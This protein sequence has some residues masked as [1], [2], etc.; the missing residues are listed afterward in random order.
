MQLNQVKGVGDAT[1]IKLNKLGINT[2]SDLIEFFPSSYLDMTKVIDINEAVEGEHAVIRVNIEQVSPV[3]YIRKGMSIVKAKGYSSGEK[4]ELTWFN[5]PY[6]A[7]SLTVGDYYVWGRVDTYGNSYC[8]INASVEKVEENRYLRGYSSVYALKGEIGQKTFKKILAAAID[9]YI[10]DTPFIERLSLKDAA[11]KVHFPKDVKQMRQGQYQFALNAVAE[12][13]VVYRLSRKSLQTGKLIYLPADISDAIRGLPFSLS[14]SQIRALKDIEADLESA[15]PMNR[16]LL[17]DVGC[18]KTVVALLSMLSVALSGGQTVLLCPTEILCNQ[19]YLKALELFAKYDIM[20]DKLCA[21]M[22]ASERNRVKSGLESGEI[23]VLVATHSCLSASVNFAN[24]KFAVIDELH[25]FGVE[26]KGILENKNN[27]VDILVMSATPVPRSMAMIIY[28]D[29]Q[30]SLL[31]KRATNKDNITTYLFTS[32]KFEGMIGYLRKKVESGQQCYLVCPRLE[33]ADGEEMYSAKGMYKTLIDKG[34]D[35]DTTA[36]IYGKLAPDKKAK[37]MRDFAQGKTKLLVATTVVEVGIDVPQANTMVIM[38]ADSLG[39]ASLHQL[40]GR[41]G[42]D[43]GQAECFLHLRSRK[44]SDRMRVMRECNDGIK[45]AVEDAKLR[46]YGDLIGVRQ[47]GKSSY[48]KYKL[49]I[50]LGMIKQAKKLADSV[51][52]SDKELIE[53]Y[54]EYIPTAENITLN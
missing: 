38:C 18:G 16:I 36:L 47:S 5:M 34:F 52:L 32:A 20:V 39:L 37:V 31:D 12:D 44:I 33:N 8:I 6:I 29:L 10:P 50:T 41:I 40:R 23:K 53:R 27:G 26:Q 1:L 51:D 30:L 11:Y 4:L 3:R 17:G 54:R 22:G 7:S 9:A 24:L 42:R 13:L 48:S 14:D 43:G 2:L 21:S 19:H 25:K 28:G 46:G 49:K 15:Q 35:K 45:L